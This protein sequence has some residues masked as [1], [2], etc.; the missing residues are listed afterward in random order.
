ME[1]E[2]IKLEDLMDWQKLSWVKTF[3][4]RYANAYV[5]H[6]ECGGHGK[7]EMNE[8]LM[9]Q[10]KNKIVEFGG[11]VPP[12]EEALRWGQFNAEGST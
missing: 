8:R 12:R 9:K 3:R 7:A 10:W 5:T 11:D 2:D 1:C 6:C 4:I